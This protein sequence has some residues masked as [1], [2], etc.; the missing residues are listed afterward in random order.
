M[1]QRK[2]YRKRI[3]FTNLQIT[4]IKYISDHRKHRFELVHEHKKQPNLLFI[5]K[6]LIL[7]VIVDCRTTAVHK[8]RIELRF[9]QYDV[10]SAKAQSVSL[11][12][13]VNL[14]GE[15]CKHNRVDLDFYDHKLAIE[16]DENGNRHRNFDYEI[17]MQKAREEELGCTFIRTDPGKEECDIFKANN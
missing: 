8:F 1:F 3:R 2:I 12:K 11:N 9:K 13:K 5:N 16:I 7:K 14:K 10:I 17:K 4:T 6:K 15:T